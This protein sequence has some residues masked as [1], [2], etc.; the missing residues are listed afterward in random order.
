MSTKNLR[1]RLDQLEQRSSSRETKAE[2]RILPFEFSIDPAIVEELAIER[3]FLEFVE[4]SRSFGRCSPETPEEIQTKARMA[5]LARTILC[6]P[7]YGF[8]EYW[9]DAGCL[10]PVSK[11][12]AEGYV[13]SEEERN[14]REARMA[15]Y[16]RTPEGRARRRL[17]DL[18]I[19]S[20]LI[21]LGPVEFEEMERLIKMYPEPWT[22]PTSTSVVDLLLKNRGTVEDRKRRAQKH[23]RWIRE[24]KVSREARPT[25]LPVTVEVKRFIAAFRK[26]GC[27]PFP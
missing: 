11:Q 9:D 6:P 22:H 17:N 20:P 16:E 2:K 10:E 3:R 18:E 26:N 27:D 25:S 15:S 1:S 24:R 23:Q 13:E 14:L 21:L 8:K 7:S 5:A 12:M 4:G 19:G